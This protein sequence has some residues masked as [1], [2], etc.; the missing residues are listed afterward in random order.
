MFAWRRFAALVLPCGPPL[1]ISG[2]R[3]TGLRAFGGAGGE[4]T[5]ARFI[6]GM[7]AD[8][9]ATRKVTGV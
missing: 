8:T 9:L 2:E 1:P 3:A 6:V 5:F 7:I 4:C